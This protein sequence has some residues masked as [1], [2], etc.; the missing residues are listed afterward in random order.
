M[1]NFGT[2]NIIPN[3]SIT[4]P[5]TYCNGTATANLLVTKADLQ[6]LGISGIDTS[7]A[8]DAIN[9]TNSQIQVTLKFNSGAGS[10][11]FTLPK[12]AIS[13]M[14]FIDSFTA[15]N[16]LTLQAGNDVELGGTLEKNTIV[17]LNNKEL[18]FSGAGKVGVGWSDASIMEASLNV[19]YVPDVGNNAVIQMDQRPTPG[20]PYFGIYTWTYPNHI[21]YANYNIGT[22]YDTAGMYIENRWDNQGGTGIAFEQRAGGADTAVNA[23][24]KIAWSQLGDVPR[25]IN[26][27]HFGNGRAFQIRA[28]S[29]ALDTNYNKWLSND[30]WETVYWLNQA[31]KTRAFFLIENQGAYTNPLIDWVD[32]GASSGTFFRIVKGTPSTGT[33]LEVLHSGSGRALVVDTRNPEDNSRSAVTVSRD[34]R[35]S[36]GYHPTVLFDNESIFNVNGSHQVSTAVYDEDLDLGTPFVGETKPKGLYMKVIIMNG[37]VPRTI[38]LNNPTSPVGREYIIKNVSNEILTVNAPAGYTFDDLSVSKTLNIWGTLR[39][40]SADCDPTPGFSVRWLAV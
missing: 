25:S 6:Q 33:A 19:K 15:S 27:G 11:S 30:N 39:L 18:R 3:T 32:A 24:T 8:F 12:S 21:G 9:A 23:V 17:T 2:P 7:L 36:V 26:I 5:F 35:L 13:G 1:A 4:Y 28:F 20:T 34:G 10:T 22:A 37:S 40:V 29:T 14:G 31:N 38:T 16:G